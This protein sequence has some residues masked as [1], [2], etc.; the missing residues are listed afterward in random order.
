MK[1]GRKERETY[2]EALAVMLVQLPLLLL[3]FCALAALSR[4]TKEHPI[5]P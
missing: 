4:P 1:S 5:S 2:L 3:Y